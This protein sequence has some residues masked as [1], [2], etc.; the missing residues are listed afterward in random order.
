MFSEKNAAAGVT[1]PKG[2]KAA[3]VKAGIKK[4]GN[5]DLALIY[6][7][8]EA[9]VAGVFT[10]NA[11]AAAPVI[12]SREVVKGGK[13]HA[14]VANAGCANACTGETGLANARKMA[15]L[16]A[17]EV[18]CA[19]DEVLVGST[20]IIGVNLPMDKLE[21]GIKAAAAELSEDGSKNA[22][23]AIITT[24]TYS[25][26]CSCEVEIGGQAVRF[27][28]IA[29]GSG[30]IQPNMATML[31]YITTDAN[32]SSQLMQK[33]LSEIVEVSFNMISVDGDMSTNDT[34]L[35]L[36]NGASGAAEITDGSPEYDKFYAT[37]KEIC[38]ELSK[39]I[40]A[41][42]EGATK[43]LTI[44]VSGTKTFEDAKTVAMSIAKSPLVKTAF[45]GEDPNWGR[46]ICAV[47]YAGIPM[48]PEKTVIKFGGV[49]VYANGL[50]AEFNEDDIHKVMAEHDIVIDVEMGMGDAKATVWS[51]DFSY[52]YVKINGEYHT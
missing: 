46:V 38:Q 37:L 25:K 12:V 34:V 31:C 17:A 21:A 6:T 4:S 14:I 41:D 32:I 48:V 11:V 29:K 33:A 45:F 1:F 36:A 2:F 50:G 42:G 5:L 26:A 49:P 23:N 43:F 18:G 39:R 52:E 40:A 30:M 16:A 9:A 13:A 47:G 19:S 28:A 35:V 51:C 22:G 3:G 7:E 20:G 27:G 15:A 8:K 24:D 44:N 10:K